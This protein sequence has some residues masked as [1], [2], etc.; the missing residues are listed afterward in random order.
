MRVLALVAA[1]FRF[2]PLPKIEKPQT[3]GTA[4]C[5]TRRTPYEGKYGDSSLPSE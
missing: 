3:A 5:A 2:T 4:V 1:E